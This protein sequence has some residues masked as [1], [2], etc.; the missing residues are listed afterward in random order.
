[1]RCR[2]DGRLPHGGGHV[3]DTNVLTEDNELTLALLHIGWRI[4]APR[5]CTL[6]TEIMPT[7]NELSKQRLR[8]KRGAFENLHDYGF[9]RITAPYWG[10]QALSLVSV[11]ATLAYL[12]TT[13]GTA[14]LGV[15]S[16]QPFWLGVTAIFVLERVV[17]V[18]ER[19][20][21]QQLCAIPLLIEMPFDLFLQ[22][23]QARAYAEVVLRREAAW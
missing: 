16:V 3:Y 20:W 17:T 9:T 6:T 5:E 11:L 22:A 23:V 13:I 7:W 14:A 8:W 12:G 2:Q 10:R 19:G 21:K 15:F 4:L 1:V 18:R